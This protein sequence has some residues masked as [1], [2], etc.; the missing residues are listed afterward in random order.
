MSALYQVPP[1][2]PSL[3]SFWGQEAGE[4]RGGEGCRLGAR[5]SW[6]PSRLGWRWPPRLEVPA[7]SP[8]PAVPALLGAGRCAL[9]ACVVGQ[10]REGAHRVRGGP[11]PRR[12][13]LATGGAPAGALQLLALGR[14]PTP[15]PAGLRAAH[16]VSPR[17]PRSPTAPRARLGLVWRRRAWVRRE[18][19]LP[20][21][22]GE[23]GFPPAWDE[24]R[25]CPRPISSSR[26]SRILE[27]RRGEGTRT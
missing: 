23:L 5:T 1:F 25:L 8:A 21:P 3:S 4:R 22:S 27:V 16:R 14:A 20:R 7:R 15:P 19:G 18:V 6:E 24:P 26:G 13:A 10:L 2:C 9:R 17:W 11:C 12:T